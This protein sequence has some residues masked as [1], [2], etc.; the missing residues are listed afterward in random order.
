MMVELGLEFRT[1]VSLPVA[2]QEE[3]RNLK[4][5]E[6][7]TLE[8]TLAEIS[9]SN[10]SLAAMSEAKENVRKLM[11][12]QNLYQTSIKKIH[13]ITGQNL[14][15]IHPELSSAQCRSFNLAQ[16]FQKTLETSDWKFRRF[17]LNHIFPD[18]VAVVGNDLFNFAEASQY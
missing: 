13:I 12:Y 7:F 4:S 16:A 10:L 9:G 5:S 2:L 8:Q 15:Q 18:L 11:Q 17:V 3:V 1:E 14:Q 6:E